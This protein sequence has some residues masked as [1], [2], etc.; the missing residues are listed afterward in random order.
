MKRETQWGDGFADLLNFICQHEHIYIFGSA[1]VT[2]DGYGQSTTK[3][4]GNARSVQGFRQ[5]EKLVS[6]IHQF[7][8]DEM[9][10]W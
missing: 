1:G 4:I 3:G 5:G 10:R 7:Y 9:G 8:A 6:K 2:I